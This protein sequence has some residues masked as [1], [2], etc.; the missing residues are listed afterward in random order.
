MS[1]FRVDG[2]R[3]KGAAPL[4]EGWEETMLD[5]CLLGIMGEVYTDRLET[6]DA[7]QFLIG[8]FCFFA[9][10]P[11]EELVRNRPRHS[12][13]AIMCGDGEGWHKLI[14]QVYGKRA[15]KVARYAMK[16]EGD[17]FDR[18]K[19]CQAAGSLP[20]GYEMRLIDA[21]IYRMTQ[22]EEWSKDLCSQF[23]DAEDYVKRGVGIGVLHRGKLAAGASSYTVYDKGIEIE[24]D[25]K[26]EY[27]RQGLAY[28]AGA[29]LILECLRRGLYPSWDA[30]NL[31]SVALA[32]KLGYHV[33]HEYTAYEVMW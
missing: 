2:E 9:G 4:V 24:I 29:G 14:E 20:K 15:K 27:R 6:L 7:A 16:K 1:I 21:R 5:S 22:E 8:D 32:E 30:Q 17:V 12:G 19:L 33:D 18:T 3:L 10:E 28:A 26:P 23:P 25:T 11:R 31:W 13:F